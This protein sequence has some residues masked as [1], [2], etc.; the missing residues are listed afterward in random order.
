M[1]DLA[2]LPAPPA[3][4]P[5][6]ATDTLPMGRPPMLGAPP[7]TPTVGYAVPLGS[8]A[9]A[10]NPKA[11]VTAGGTSQGDATQ[12]ATPVAIVSGAIAGGGVVLRGI[13]HDSQTVL[14]SSGLVILVYPPVIA[15]GSINGLA[16]AGPV[17]L[18]P[19]VEATFHTED[20]VA[21]FVA[22]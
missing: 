9:P 3:A 6:A 5:V 4:A 11:R 10:I 21:Y 20:G 17:Q 8:L 16:A 14:N 1:P 15:N 13:E 22:L 2:Q 18:Q 7:G 12:L 19:G